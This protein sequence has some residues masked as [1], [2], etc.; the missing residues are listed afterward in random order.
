M[1]IK[2][3]N[4]H[5]IKYYYYKE[6]Q[7]HIL[8]ALEKCIASIYDVVYNTKEGF[9]NKKGKKKT[10]E[11]MKIFSEIRNKLYHEINNNKQYMR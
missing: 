11:E 10:E 3:Q 9:F 8:L 7:D 2:L 1:L 4:R 5:I 6:T